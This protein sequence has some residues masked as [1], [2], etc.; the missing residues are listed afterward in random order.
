M[1]ENKDNVLENEYIEN[2]ELPIENDIIDESDIST[3]DNTK[4]LTGSE[5]LVEDG[6]DKEPEI[7][8]NDDRTEVPKEP[9]IPS[10]NETTEDNEPV[11]EDSVKSPKRINPL[12][13]ISKKTIGDYAIRDIQTNSTWDVNP[14]SADDYVIVPDDMVLDILE[15]KGFC[16]IVLNEDETEIIS[17]TSKEIPDIKVP[18][19]DP[20]IDD[21][22]NRLESDILNTQLALA[23]QYESDITIE[24]D[25]L[26]TQLALAEQYEANIA[27]EED[28]LRTQLALAEQYEANILLEETINN[29][30]QEIESLKQE[31]E[32]I[33]FLINQ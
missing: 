12:C 13:V 2:Q 30:K 3:G 22:V 24:D 14:Y 21:R 9:N 19:P 4:E 10:E 25:I 29:D 1:T 17:F 32:E 26:R 31:L 20:S 6:T 16:D 33:K 11:E 18:D 8:N 28:L 27:I 23:E 5:D 7:S 15:T